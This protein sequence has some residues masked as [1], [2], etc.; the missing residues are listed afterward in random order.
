MYVPVLN[1]FFLSKNT[2]YHLSM[3]AYEIVNDEPETIVDYL[4][5]ILNGKN[6]RDFDHRQIKRLLRVLKKKFNGK[7]G[8]ELLA[9]NPDLISSRQ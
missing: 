5:N 2:G 7:T 4:Q 8:A 9:E 1:E 6:S 3:N